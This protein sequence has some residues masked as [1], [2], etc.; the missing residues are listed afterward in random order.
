MLSAGLH[1]FSI[2]LG[3]ICQCYVRR[4]ATC[5]QYSFARAYLPV[6]PPA[7]QR[8]L[9]LACTSG[10]ESRSD[11]RTCQS[12]SEHLYSPYAPPS[13]SLIPR[14]HLYIEIEDTPLIIYTHSHPALHTTLPPPKKSLPQTLRKQHHLSN[15]PGYYYKIK[16]VSKHAQE[17][18]LPKL[19]SIHTETRFNGNTVDV[20]G[21]IPYLDYIVSRIFIYT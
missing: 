17:S 6:P 14:W 21:Q 15:S 10:G 19:I 12:G 18:H 4:G 11:R 1:V 2:V 20:H 3:P 9:R 8:F 7:V 13:H 5:I 16:G